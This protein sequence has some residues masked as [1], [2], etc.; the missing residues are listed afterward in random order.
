MES[1][2]LT[3]FFFTFLAVAA[4]LPF[5][6]LPTACNAPDSSAPADVRLMQPPSSSLIDCHGLPHAVPM[7]AAGRRPQR[8]WARRGRIKQNDQSVYEPVG[9]QFVS[10]TATA[11]L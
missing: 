5:V 7:S 10:T 1:G 3:V 8:S 9:V 4:A 11:T 6:A 2:A